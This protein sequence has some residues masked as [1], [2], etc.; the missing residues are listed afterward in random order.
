MTVVLCGIGCDTTNAGRVAPIYEDGR[1][2]YVPIPEKTHETEET[3]T[4]GTWS[5]RHDEGVAA[6]LL[7]A[8]TPDPSEGTT[9]RG[10]A[11]REWPLH[12]DP[13]FEAL[14]YGEHRPNYVRRL[15]GLEPGD[16]VGFY[17]GLRPPGGGRAHRYLIGYTSVNCVDVI[18]P[19][20]S[21]EE[22]GELFDA[23]PENAHA[24]RART[25]G[26][27]Y[28]EETVVLVDGR[29]PGGLFERD[30]VQMSVYEVKPDNERPQYYLDPAFAER[31]AVTEGR[32]NMQFKPAYL[33]DLDG[34]AFV[35]DVGAE[36]TGR[37][38][39][40]IE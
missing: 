38:N 4:H 14:A 25:G 26:R 37:Q 32:D 30:P 18:P 12:H 6:D 9:V 17:A 11:L 19:G 20:T 29:E 28:D 21:R 3:A 13:N 39:L 35:E 8:I 1:F 34:G 31:F 10:E 22:A 2:E 7:S 16:V 5:L 15:R 33:C 40:L 36:S 24:K 27:F 23:H